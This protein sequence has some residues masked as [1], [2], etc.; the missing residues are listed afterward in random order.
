MNFNL[1]YKTHPAGLYLPESIVQYYH[2]SVQP[3]YVEV[4]NTSTV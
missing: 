4:S 1:E 2:L 3:L